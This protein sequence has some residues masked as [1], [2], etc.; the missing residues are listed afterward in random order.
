MTPF[1]LYQCKAGLCLMLFTGLYYL[2]FRKETF[3]T[4]NRFYLLGSLLVSAFLPL[5]Q[6]TGIRTGKSFFFSRTIDAITVYSGKMS[7]PA[8]QLPHTN[9]LLSAAYFSV[10][11]LF[12][13]YFLF[14]F[15]NLVIFMLRNDARQLSGNKLIYMSDKKYSFSFFRYIFLGKDQLSETEPQILQHEI[16]HARQWHSFD[17]VIIQFIKIFQWFNP[18]IYL[19]ENALKETHEYL[20]DAAVLEHD[21]SSERYRM[22]LLTRVFGVQP[23]IFNYFNRLNFKNRFTMMTKEKSPSRNRLKYLAVLP[24]FAFLL[25]VFCC[26][27]SKGQDKPLK[28]ANSQAPDT[29]PP[30]MFVEKDAKFHDGNLETFRAWVQENLVYPQPAVENGIYGRV[31]VSFV[32]NEKGEVTNVAILRGVD[33]ILDKETIRVITSSPKWEPGENDGLKVKQQLTIPVIFTLK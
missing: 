17:V 23:G 25:F 13:I 26:P 15:I 7:S 8:Q 19:T 27:P 32:V 12:V 6:I 18:F 5:I 30:F 20:A 33:P 4:F 29:S 14:Q 11:S 2:I 3:H 28:Q 1:M 16:A 31:I 9:H 24:M 22:L 10:V 21:G